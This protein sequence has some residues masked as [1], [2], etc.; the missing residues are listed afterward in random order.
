MDRNKKKV[1][2]KR[3]SN[4]IISVCR[5]RLHMYV[6]LSRFP[7]LAATLTYTCGDSRDQNLGHECWCIP[8]CCA[9]LLFIVISRDINTSK[10][11]GAAKAG[12]RKERY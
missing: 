5:W 2:R 3:N 6:V 11:L 1:R 8:P 10:R 4:T 7:F 12:S 9:A